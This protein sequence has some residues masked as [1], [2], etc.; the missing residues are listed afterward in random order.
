MRIA[1]EERPRAILISGCIVMFGIEVMARRCVASSSRLHNKARINK[2]WSSDTPAML[3]R[4]EHIGICW[5]A[6]RRRCAGFRAIF[7]HSADG[8]KCQSDKK[9][10][11]GDAVG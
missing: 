5:K 11:T 1:G 6:N 8:K 2:Y 4:V 10:T 9:N 3:L 7:L